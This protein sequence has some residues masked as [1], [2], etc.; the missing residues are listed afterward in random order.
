M[1]QNTCS[2]AS[3]PIAA[4]YSNVLDSTNYTRIAILGR[5]LARLFEIRLHCVYNKLQI[6]SVANSEFAMNSNGAVTDLQ[7][8]CKIIC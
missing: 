7:I 4:P 5:V 1:K 3:Q 8:H 6:H 2:S